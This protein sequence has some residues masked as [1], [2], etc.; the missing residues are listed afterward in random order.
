MGNTPTNFP[1]KSLMRIN[2]FMKTYSNIPFHRPLSFMMT[3]RDISGNLIWKQSF[4]FLESLRDIFRLSFSIKTFLTIFLFRTAI[5]VEHRD[6][7]FTKFWK[8]SSDE[9]I[10]IKS[11]SWYLDFHTTGMLML[12]QS[13]VALELCFW[14][15]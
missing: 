4:S 6:I 14:C 8:H 12:S 13:C 9:F 2:L 15:Y 11:R 1:L 5:F 10:L 3:L 7:N